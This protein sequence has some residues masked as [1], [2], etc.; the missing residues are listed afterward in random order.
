MYR[1]K[2]CSKYKRRP[3]WIADGYEYS[4]IGTE[5]YEEKL[6]DNG[7][8]LY[9]DYVLTSST[10]QTTNLVHYNWG[11]NGDFNGLYAPV[12]GIYANGTTFNGL[13]MI[14]SIRLAYVL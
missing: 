13:K 11:W 10:V 1:W 12:N 4:R 8:R 3:T 7:L 2:G 5:F 14:T 6:I 9:Y